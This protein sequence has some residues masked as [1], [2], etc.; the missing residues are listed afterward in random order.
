MLQLG[1]CM[2]HCMAVACCTA[3]PLHVAP[4]WPVHAAPW[5]LRA[6][7]HG[8]CLLECCALGVGG[9][10]LDSA[11]ALANMDQDIQARRKREEQITYYLRSR[12]ARHSRSPR[13]AAVRLRRV[14]GTQQC[15]PALR[16]AAL[17]CGTLARR[18]LAPQ[19][20]GCGCVCR[21]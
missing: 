15:C 5:P 7:P 4:H 19:G 9:G 8:R 2:L 12:K 18:R 11:A 14:C 1:R 20:C 13:H 6:A 10:R 3:W 21:E 16:N 17:R